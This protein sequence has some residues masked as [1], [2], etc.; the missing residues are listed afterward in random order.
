LTGGVASLD[1]GVAAIKRGTAVFL[2]TVVAAG[3]G[4][5]VGFERA[6]TPVFCG[7]LLL[8][9]KPVRDGSGVGVAVATG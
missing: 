7:V 2:A 8:M 5:G 6:A 3:V 4:V 1:A 9:F